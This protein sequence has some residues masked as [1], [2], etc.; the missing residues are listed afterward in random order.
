MPLQWQGSVQSTAQSTSAWKCV[1]VW[2]RDSVCKCVM[3]VCVC[4]CI[5]DWVCVI[6]S[7]KRQ[8]HAEFLNAESFCVMTTKWH[9]SLQPFFPS[10]SSFF[11]V[12]LSNMF[13]HQWL[14]ADR[15]PYTSIVSSS[16]LHFLISALSVLPQTRFFSHIL[17][18]HRK[19]CCCSLQNQ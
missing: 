2:E 18:H 19:A 10:F 7:L 15:P 16:M 3:R 11:H 13:N 14:C 12:L 8:L 17:S 6:T 1:C 5:C 9:M 4:V